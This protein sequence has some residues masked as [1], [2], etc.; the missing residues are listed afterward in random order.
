MK[1]YISKNAVINTLEMMV[2]NID[3]K[4]EQHKDDVL[5]VNDL[6]EMLVRLEV[7]YNALPV[8]KIDDG[9]R[10]DA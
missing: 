4:Y 1:D 8:H 2:N 10:E 6:K 5:N 9:T 3:E 7:I